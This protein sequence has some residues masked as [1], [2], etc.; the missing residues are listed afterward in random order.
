MPEEQR[1]RFM[2]YLELMGERVVI[3]KWKA[4]S[5]SGVMIVL[6]NFY[7]KKMNKFKKAFKDAEMTYFCECILTEDIL[8]E[9]LR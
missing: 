7:E 1:D 2:D 8:N 5:S 3:I 9:V 6:A 4:P